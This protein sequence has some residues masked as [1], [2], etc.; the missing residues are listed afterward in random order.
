MIGDFNIANWFNEFFARVGPELARK[1]YDIDPKSF[2]QYLPPCHSAETFTFY[3]VTEGMVL[4]SLG[5]MQ[6]KC[7]QGPDG[8]STKLL[9]V[10]YH[11]PHSE[12]IDTLL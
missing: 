1:F 6:S 2:E 5:G 8:I 7:S 3:K 12:P 10:T 9:K 4:K 11:P